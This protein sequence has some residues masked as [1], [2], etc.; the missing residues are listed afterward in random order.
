MA[1]P[2]KMPKETKVSKLRPPPKPTIPVLSSTD[3]K[4][5]TELMIERAVTSAKKHGIDLY[6]GRKNVADGNCAME[7]VIFNVNDRPCFSDA[8]PFSVD[9]YR[10]LWI[11]DF[12][13]KTIDDPT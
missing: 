4:T 5:A 11:T 2:E 1:I 3:L 6:H 13:N 7:S 9:Y 8:L 12:K 10:R